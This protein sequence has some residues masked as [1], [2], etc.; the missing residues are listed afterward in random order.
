MGVAHCIGKE[1]GETEVEGCNPCLNSSASSKVVQVGIVPQEPMV[2]LTYWDPELRVVGGLA[3]RLI[4]IWQ[5][6]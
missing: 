6:L 5:I 1:C 2:L 3:G 4:A